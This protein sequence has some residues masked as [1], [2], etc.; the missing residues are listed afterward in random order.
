MRV[1]IGSVAWVLGVAVLAYAVYVYAGGSAEVAVRARGC[2]L[3]HSPEAALPCVRTLRPGEP[4]RP[5]LAARLQQAH[6][7][8]SCGAVDELTEYLLARQMPL[9]ARQRADSPGKTLYLAKCAACHGRDG[10]GRPGEFPPLR[11]SEWLTDEPGRLPEVISQG[12]T[13]PISVRGEAWDKTMLAPGISSPAQVQ[14][15]IDFLRRH[16]A[17][18]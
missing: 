3:C 7:L 11:G 4:M 12:L 18:Q 8:L 10:A 2:L 6:P 5:L 13:G 17:E 15:L 14:Q 1:L 16:F 9:W